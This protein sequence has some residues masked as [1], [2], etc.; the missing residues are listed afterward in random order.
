MRR[1]RAAVLV[2]AT[3]LATAVHALG[4]GPIEA[5]SSLNQP[6]E[7]RV[8]LV[9]ATPADLDSLA[10]RLADA[11][12][13]ERAGVGR[14]AVLLDLRFEVVSGAPGAEYVRIFSSEPLREP[15]LNFLVELVWSN[16]RLVRE[17][18]VLL[19]PPAYA[20][21]PAVAVSAPV[22]AAASV[23][24]PLPA[25]SPAQA[26]AV[27]PEVP[28]VTAA[29]VASSA[30]GA[31]TSDGQTPDGDGFFAVTPTTTAW[32]LAMRN[33]PA[34][35]ITV[36][37]MLTALVRANPEAFA[38]EN[39]HFLR[40]TARLRLPGEQEARALDA[41]AARAEFARQTAQRDTLLAPATRS[42]DPTAAPAAEVVRQEAPPPAPAAIAESAAPAPE[43]RAEVAPAQ[44]AEPP[45]APAE[46]G[47]PP[48]AAAASE[49]E[50]FAGMD[51]TPPD[52]LEAALD[53]TAP[54]ADGPRLK[55]E[56]PELADTG[57]ADGGGAGAG[58][59]TDALALEQADVVARENEELKAK[60]KESEEII[61]LFQQQ[62][63]DKDKE[64][65]ALQ[66][67][68]AALEAATRA[69][70]QGTS[71]ANTLPAS[72]L[73]LEDMAGP[74][75]GLPALGLL[76]IVG[77][78]GAW[79][80]YRRRQSGTLLTRPAAP[81]VDDDAVLPWSPPPSSGL[82]VEEITGSEITRLQTV[83]MEAP[84]T[85][86][87]PLDEVNVLLAYERF[88]QAEELVRNAIRTRPDH[89]AYQL[90][91][92]E[93]F[94]AANRRRSFEEAARALQATVGS[95]SPLWQ[96]AVAMWQEMSPQRPLFAPDAASDTGAMDDGIPSTE[97][98]DISAPSPASAPGPATAAT[99]ALDLDLEATPE[100]G[101]PR[102]VVVDLSTGE[103]L[104]TPSRDPHAPV[105]PAVLDQSMEFDL[106]DTVWPGTNAPAT[107][108]SR[109]AD[110]YNLEFD[111]GGLG[112]TTDLAQALAPEQDP[113]ARSVDL[114]LSLRDTGGSLRAPAAS[115]LEP[116]SSE[117]ELEFDLALQDT[118]DLDT[119]NMR[120]VLKDLEQ[121]VIAPEQVSEE[122][123]AD[124]TRS[125]EA[126]IASLDVDSGPDLALEPLDSDED[127]D[128][129]FTLDGTTASMLDTLSLDP[130]ALERTTSERAPGDVALDLD[131]DLDDS[132]EPSPLYETDTKLSLAKAY[133]EL[134][135]AEGAREILDEV[136]QTGNAVQQEEARRLLAP[137][138]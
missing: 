52:A 26:A 101:A 62:I 91:L 128:F 109:P 31:G 54:A 118:T 133:L 63:S 40:R 45:S 66:A 90:R 107:P 6:F 104:G 56:V 115:H 28:A 98:V 86:I 13:F 9:G 15:F 120:E 94:Y 129:E 44:P 102:P 65:A 125:M 46:V 72:P 11:A 42:S 89:P 64:L 137:R 77:L 3:L 58:S 123:L 78:L 30:V 39:V 27:A 49:D 1:T 55:L 80:A 67:R 131:L 71:A 60:A 88:E 32:G 79:W 33:R 135:D 37:Q 110:D 5:T 18:T 14:E 81:A 114:D 132:D 100:P 113:L 105:A 76:G 74:F 93:V 57:Q 16:G 8:P 92:L 121:T 122:S 111:I 97:F 25:A 117:D 112:D 70:A 73:G 2:M 83:R 69:A 48:A 134:G 23:S 51:E 4:L 96:D 12:Q 119:V 138:G 19:D 21:P 36:Y 116:A 95:E 68:V 17:Y 82:S 124:I 103:G 59:A 47:A 99:P 34:P 7:A 20:V 10:A 24:T 130:G 50:L 106:A 75:T 108:A 61:A 53:A 126:S 87:D 85:E 35:D 29:P 41:A 43:V 38:H 136:L 22:V 84:P 127:R